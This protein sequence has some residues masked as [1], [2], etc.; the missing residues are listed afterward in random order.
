MLLDPETLDLAPS[1][2]EVLGAARRRPALQAR[3]AR[4]A[5]RDRAAAGARRVA[6]ARSPSSRRRARDARARGRRARRGPPAPGVHPFAAADGRAQ[7]RR[8]LRARS[9]REYGAVARRQLVFGLQVHVAVGGADRTLAVYNALRSLPPGARR[10]GRQRAVPR[11]P[12]HRPRLG[13]AADLPSCCRARA[14]RRRS[15]AGRR[16]AGELAGA[17][18]AGAFA[19]PRAVVVGAAAAP[20]LRHA[21]GARA[22]RA[23]DR[24][25]G[26]RASPPSRT[27][28]SRGW[29]S[30]TTPASALAGAE[31]GGSRRTAGRRCRHGLDGE[32]ADLATGERGPTRERLGALLD[33]LEPVAE[34]LGAAP[35]W[36]HAR[37]LVERNGA[38]RG[39]AR[40]GRR[41]R[42][43]PRGWPT[44]SWTALTGTPRACP[45][46]PSPRG[47]AVRAARS[48]A[49]VGD[50]RDRLPPHCVAARRRADAARRRRPPARALPSATSCTTA[51]STAS[52][53]A[54]SGS[55][56]CSRCA[57]CSSASSRP[58]LLT[59][60]GAAAGSRPA[61]GRWTSRCAAIADADDAP[62]LSRT[63]SARGTREQFLEFLVH[64]SAYQLK[65]ADPHS[66][67][68]P[69]LTG[70][71]E[72]GAG[73]DP[74]RRVR[75]RARRAHPRRS[76]SPTR[77]RRSGSTHATAP[78]STRI[79]GVTLATVNLM[80]LFGPAPPLARRDRRATSRC[81]R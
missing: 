13:P 21:R 2:R 44:R 31:T 74:G 64:R 81:S 40:R 59:R 45:R 39:S 11:G 75:R 65:E 50:L 46:C 16:F 72:G 73:R 3:A 17:R 51:A 80:S 8:A 22:R 49:C 37:A 30:A 33:E 23:D 71:A 20:A 14:S 60:V 76:C 28:S 32:F 52:T 77:W 54:G 78:T 56:R 29:P 53:S 66:W 5:A 35:S 12:R 10:A 34:R 61:R 38:D 70:R 79:P 36:R 15:R 1:P 57:R 9:T 69:R 47:A 48:S 62:S 43:W 41:P 18:A 58:A 68:L 67:A 7:P 24:R 27:R 42:G 63:S 4:R 26:R 19:E 6:R 55:R 25:R